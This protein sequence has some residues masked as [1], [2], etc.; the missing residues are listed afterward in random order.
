MSEEFSGGVW[1]MD[2]GVLASFVGGS[3]LWKM[4]LDTVLYL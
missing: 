1:C 4:L 3:T 2:E